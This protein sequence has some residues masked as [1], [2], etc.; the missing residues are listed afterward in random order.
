MKYLLL[1]IL[2]V[3]AQLSIAATYK[4]TNTIY[5]LGVITNRDNVDY[6]II[7]GFTSAGT[8]PLSLGLVVARFPNNE[9]GSR[10]YSMALAAKMSGRNIELGVDDSVKNAEGSCFVKTLELKD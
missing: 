3:S 7:N 6:I 8:C 1:T 2:L 5:R 4:S 10:A 9:Q